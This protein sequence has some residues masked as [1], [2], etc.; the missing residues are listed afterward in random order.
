MKY[1]DPFSNDRKGQSIVEFALMVP[2]LL[3]CI[4]VFLEISF[5]VYYK[6]VL[7]HLLLDVARIVAVS[8]DEPTSQTNSKIQSVIDAYANQGAIIF[9]TKD[10]SK[11]SV[12]WQGPTVENVIYKSIVVRARYTGIRLPFVGPL[13]VSDEIIFPYVDHEMILP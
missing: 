1:F 9:R 4:M 8:K 7:N 12:S 6:M 11:F 2:L 10:S 5:N 13:P 3:M